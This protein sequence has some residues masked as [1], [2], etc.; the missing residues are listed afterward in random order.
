MKRSTFSAHHALL[1][2]LLAFSVAC[3]PVMDSECKSLRDCPEGLFCQLGACVDLS[4]NASQESTPLAASDAPAPSMDAGTAEDATAFIDAPTENG[5]TEA[6]PDEPP[7]PPC[8]DAPDA[9]AA[10]A[11]SLV[12]NELL[13]KVPMGPDGDANADGVRHFHDDEFV[14]LVNISDQT[15]DLT[16]VTILNDTHVRFTFPPTCLEPLHA[17]VVFGGIEPGADLPAGE[18]YESFVADTRFAYADGGGRAVVR[19][20]SGD[21]I[22][23]YTYGAHPAQS[24]NLNLDLHGDHYVSHGELSDDEA[25]F[26]P[27]TCSNGQPFPTGCT[28][29]EEAQQPDGD[30][31]PSESSE[32]SGTTDGSSEGES[33]DDDDL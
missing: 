12:L 1:V 27:G 30:P 32:A 24:L 4:A 31:S 18:G 28:G 22:A 2:A 33:G 19:D 8:P 7:P 13:A 6:A 26:S 21:P 15:I 11:D 20:A 14:E 10:N 5:P 9:P 3:Q 17:A 29:D 25:L 23:D 16:D